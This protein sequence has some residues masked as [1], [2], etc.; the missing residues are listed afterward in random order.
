MPCDMRTLSFC[1]QYRVKKLIH[2]ST[3]AKVSILNLRA[4]Y[5]PVWIWWYWQEPWKGLFRVSSSVSKYLSILGIVSLHF[6]LFIPECHWVTIFTAE[7]VRSPFEKYSKLFA[8]PRVLGQDPAEG[9]RYHGRSPRGIRSRGRVLIPDCT[10]VV[11]TASVERRI[12]HLKSNVPC[13]NSVYV[14]H[15]I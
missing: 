15:H 13:P 11:H 6:T 10:I 2:G 5:S 3:S 9:R 7:C 12:V 14:T 8:V 1:W 4:Q